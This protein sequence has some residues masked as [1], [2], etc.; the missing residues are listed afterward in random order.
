VAQP[1][2]LPD[3]HPGVQKHREQQ[4]I[5]QVLAGIQ[6]PLHLTGGEDLHAGCWRRQGDGASSLSGA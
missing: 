5:P 1:Q 4:P 3:A 2:R 6:D